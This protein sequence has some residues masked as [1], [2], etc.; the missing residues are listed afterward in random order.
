[1][2]MLRSCVAPA[3]ATGPQHGDPIL[4]VYVETVNANAALD[5]RRRQRVRNEIQLTECSEKAWLTPL[6]CAFRFLAPD[7]HT[8]NASY[9]FKQSESG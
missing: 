5:R 8:N 2:G 3:F 1:M 9:L 4:N 6:E 7:G